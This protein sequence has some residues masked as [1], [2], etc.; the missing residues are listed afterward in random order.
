MVGRG[1]GTVGNTHRAQICQIEFFELIIVLTLDKQVS[2]EQFEPT[3]SQ[4]TVSAS[5]LSNGASRGHLL[6]GHPENPRLRAAE[7]GHHRLGP[8]APPAVNSH[9]V[10]LP[11]WHLP[12]AVW[13]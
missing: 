12:D 13:G 10:R 9:G 1:D 7:L 11:T 4:S 5:P 8:A 6:G 2:I 3:A